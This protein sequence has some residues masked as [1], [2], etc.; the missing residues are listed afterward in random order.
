MIIDQCH[1]MWQEPTE[2]LSATFRRKAGSNRHVNWKLIV[3]SLLFALDQKI[4]SSSVGHAN[5]KFTK[6]IVIFACLTINA[7]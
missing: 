3:A 7:G 6:V 5:C 4:M 2:V 1:D